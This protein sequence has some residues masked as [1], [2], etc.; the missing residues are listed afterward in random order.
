MK[1]YYIWAKFYNFELKNIKKIDI[2]NKKY[3]P[4]KFNK[5][6]KYSHWFYLVHSNIF[7]PYGPNR[8]IQSYLV[9]SVYLSSIRSNSILFIALRSYLVHSVHIGSIRSIFVLFCP[10]RSILSTLVH[11]S[12]FG[13]FSALW[14]YSFHFG[15]IWSILSTSVQFVH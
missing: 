6:G 7:G 9:Y 2:R 1:F 8:S 12:L 11:F 4:W 14:S 15:S 10:L 3:E 13:S 5:N